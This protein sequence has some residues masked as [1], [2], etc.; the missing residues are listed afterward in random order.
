[1]DLL[2]RPPLPFSKQP[3]PSLRVPLA[4]LSCPITQ[5]SAHLLGVGG[6]PLH[7]LFAVPE[8]PP[9]LSFW[10]PPGLCLTP[11]HFAELS[12]CMVGGGRGEGVIRV[13]KGAWSLP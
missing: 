2:P 1:M 8:L 12:V 6:V 10:G 11:V 5:T 13:I 9:R 3:S 7:P 4:T